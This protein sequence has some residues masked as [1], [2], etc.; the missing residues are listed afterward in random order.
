MGNCLKMFFVL[1]L[2]IR[3]FLM[4]QNDGIWR[5]KKNSGMEELKDCDPWNRSLKMFLE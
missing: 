3:I 1:W 4:F 2:E 5:V